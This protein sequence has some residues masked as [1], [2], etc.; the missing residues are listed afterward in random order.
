MIDFAILNSLFEEQEKREEELRFRNPSVSFWYNWFIVLLIFIL[1]AG[2]GWWATDISRRNRDEAVRSQV[3][4]EMDAE[5]EQMMAA[6]E[7]AER[8]AQQEQADLQIAEAKAIARALFGIRNF[9]E[10]YHYSNS[11][12]LTYARCITNRAEATGKSIE[13]ILDEPNQF[14]AYSSKNNLETG[15][16]DLALQFVADWH[17]G[18]L[19][20]CDTKYK[21]AVLSEMGIWLVDDPN[22][23]VPER[24]HA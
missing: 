19:P 17:D 12:L 22:K 10:K 3:L 13:E 11:D 9:T 8:Q 24:W 16:Y 6:A 15:L 14:I 4:A 5:H 20:E 23:S 1:F 7:E 18:K 21:Y 2:F